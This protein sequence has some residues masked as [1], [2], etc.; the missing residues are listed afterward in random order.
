MN[1]QEI[2]K[3]NLSKWI[4]TLRY[5]TG[6][7]KENNIRYYLSASGLEYILGSDIYP[8]DIDLFMHK[9]DIQKVYE[10]LKDYAVS[11]LHKW[12]DK[13]LEFQG[14]YNSIPFEMCEWEKEPER[15]I[16]KPFKDFEIS[17]IQ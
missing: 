7:L 13:L 16:N 14:E 4:D 8:Y 12:E 11:D 9:E 17:I 6:V 15:L 1:Y 5:L 2:N 3:N 10:L